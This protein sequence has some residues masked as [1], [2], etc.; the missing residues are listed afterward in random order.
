MRHLNNIGI[1]FGIVGVLFAIYVNFNP[2]TEEK[3]DNRYI[4]IWFSEYS[5]P[6]AGGKVSVKGT[7]EYFET[8][9]YNFVGDM[10][11]NGKANG[12][13]VNV[14]YA[15][16]LS[17]QWNGNSNQLT[18]Q[19]VDIK[20]TPIVLKIDSDVKDVVALRNILSVSGGSFPSVEDFV[21]RGI[22]EQY[23]VV[24]L[25]DSSM[26]V[27]VDDPEGNHFEYDSM[28]QKFRYQRQPRG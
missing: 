1:I 26:R 12:K 11:I 10:E 3:H 9:F 14:V 28:K 20:S 13:L 24:R 4:G 15:L 18:V 5:Y 21:P 19:I 25:T 6:Y 8:G 22:T 2:F 23:D 16:D 7:T 17:G 27:R